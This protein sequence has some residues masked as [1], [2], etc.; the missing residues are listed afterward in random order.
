[1]AY[2]ECIHWTD[3]EL[4]EEMDGIARGAGVQLADILALNCRTEIL[5]A[6]FFSNS[7][8]G[9]DWSECTAIAVSPRGST[10]GHCWLAQNW[11]WLGRQRAALVVLHT[12]DS[13]GT[14]I[15]TLTEGGML[16]KIGLNGHGMAVGLN[17]L[18]SVDDGARPGVPVHILL[19]HA[20]SQ[21]S[22]AA[23]RKRLAAIM[24]GPG[25]GA[26]SNIP[27]ADATGDIGCFELSPAGWAE[28]Q[29]Q[30]GVVVHTNH[31]LCAPLSERQAE[32]GLTLSTE[33]RLLCAS[34]HATQRPLSTASIE[35]LLRDES[36]GFVSICRRPDPNLPVAARLESVAGIRI[37]CSARRWW[38]AP[39]VPSRVRF[40][41]APTGFR[42]ADPIVKEDVKEKYR[43]QL[44]K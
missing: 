26:G 12:R 20:L 35:E 41:E 34:S 13:Y 6:S 8:E 22:L 19:R 10:D 16:A 17:I 32:L 14:E 40:E 43:P 5:P 29:S 15:A 7:G 28:H 25:F 23:F 18:R 9:V 38:I 31:F 33:S 44:Q 1:M 27:A 4:I 2:R 36:D 11:D 21:F 3:P 42:D 30:D 24:K 37:D 39:N